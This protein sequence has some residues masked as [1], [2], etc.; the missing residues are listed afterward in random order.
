MWDLVP[1]PRTE[2]RPPLYWKCGV[3]ATTPLGTS[4]GFVSDIHHENLVASLE[5]KP[6][7]MRR[8]PYNCSSQEFLNLMLISA[9]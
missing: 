5:I 3:V 7:K 4:P 1:G 2:L 6:I 8:T 9:E